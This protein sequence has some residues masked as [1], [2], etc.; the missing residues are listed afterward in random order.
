MK[1]LGVTFDENLTF[2]DHIEGVKNKCNKRLNLL[3]ALCGKNWGASPETILYT[4][5]SYIRPII[6]YSSILFAHADEPLLKTIQAIESKA[7]KI[8]HRLPPWTTNTF[9]YSYVKFE[10]I[11]DRI[12]KL[13]KDFL[14]KNSDDNLIKPLI[15]NSKP[16][17]SGRHSAVYKVLNW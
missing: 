3:K 8:A 2:K 1:F 12:K 9:C 4:Y 17:L 7:I 10:K 16:S 14:H 11:T 5:R 13:G 15:E 6:E